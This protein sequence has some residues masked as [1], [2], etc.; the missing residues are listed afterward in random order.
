MLQKIRTTC[1]PSVFAPSAHWLIG[2]GWEGEGEGEGDGEGEAKRKGRGKEKK[3]K[4]KK[5]AD[6]IMRF[7]SHVS[8]VSVFGILND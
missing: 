3:K 1:T 6:R 7:S 8:H 5:E 2:W 4:K